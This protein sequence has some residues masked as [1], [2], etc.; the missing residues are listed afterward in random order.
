[1]TYPLIMLTGRPHGHRLKQEKIT[2]TLFR[3]SRQSGKYS[4]GKINDKDLDLIEKNCCPGAGSCAGLFTANTM[5]CMTEA[6]GMSLTGCATSLAISEKK[7]KL[8]YETGKRIV[9]LVK[10]DTKPS[11]I[12]TKEAF[13]N[14]ITVDMAIGGS[15]NTALH[16]P[17]IAKELKHHSHPR[18][19]RPHLKNNTKHL[20]NRPNGPYFMK[21][22]DN[23]GGVPAVLNA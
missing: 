11:E 8:S 7:K 16:L 5:S 23:A 10:K 15:T 20:L 6:L 3:H 12:M 9:E 22:F 13:E 14:A 1:L 17:S 19:I 4:A 18:H 21:D 2:V